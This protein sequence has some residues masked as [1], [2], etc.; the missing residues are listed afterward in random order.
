M[1]Y[2]TFIKTRMGPNLVFSQIVLPLLQTFT[3][4]LS[5]VYMYFI[6]FIFYLVPM[7]YLFNWKCWSCWSRT[8]QTHHWYQL[9]SVCFLLPISVC[10]DERFYLFHNPPYS[11]LCVGNV[12][13]CLPCTLL[14]WVA[15]HVNDPALS[16]YINLI[17]HWWC[18]KIFWS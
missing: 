12:S 1:C 13:S 9:L 11:V 15:M 18:C 3:Q 14:Q 17:S 7:T 4:H 5:L 8:I 10:L 2:Y 16:L 6:Y